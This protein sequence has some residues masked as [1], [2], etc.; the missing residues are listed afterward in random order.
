V[1]E[2]RPVRVDPR[3]LDQL[4]AQLAEERGPNREPSRLD[5]FRFELPVIEE[6]FA[7]RFEELPLTIPGR[8]DYRQIITAGRLAQFISVVGQLTTDGAIL[9]LGIELDLSAGL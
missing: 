5:F 4:D 6:V 3:F 9:L 2:R 1:N 7:L 8:P